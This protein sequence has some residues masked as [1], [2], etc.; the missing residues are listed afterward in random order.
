MNR[1]LRRGACPG[2]SA[3]MPTGDG[4]LVRLRPIGTV[5]LAAFEKLCAA[6]QEHGNGVIEVTTRGSIQVR[7]LSEQSAPLF[8]EA[9]ARLGIAT[10]DGPPVLSNP[11]AGLDSAEILDAAALAADLRNALA[12]TSLAE[13]LAPK[14]S[15][16]IDGGG[17]HLDG[18]AADIRLAAEAT[19]GGPVL[20]VGIGGDSVSA[21]ELGAVRGRRRRG[22]CP[23]A[24]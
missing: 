4:L 6:A 13:R 17:L 16:V 23:A 12:E 20:R 24:A 10:E 11:L 5:A 7:G 8:A 3:P 15:V 22:S 18:I 14:V 1:P 21:T 19:P 9:V 2:L